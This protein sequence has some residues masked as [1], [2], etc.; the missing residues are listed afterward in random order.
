M[1]TV[2]TILNT[3]LLVF[4]LFGLYGLSEQHKIQNHHDSE[5]DE[6]KDRKEFEERRK[7]H[8]WDKK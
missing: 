7:S 5:R 1:L 4:V 2:L 3:I 8:A 6:L